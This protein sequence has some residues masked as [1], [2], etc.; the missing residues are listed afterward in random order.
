VSDYSQRPKV[1]DVVRFKGGRL[2]A[3]VG[4]VG[5][6]SNITDYSKLGMAAY[7]TSFGETMAV[8]KLDDKNGANLWTL[9]HRFATTRGK[10][11]AQFEGALQQGKSTG[12]SHKAWFSNAR[13]EFAPAKLTTLYVEGNVASGGV[14]NNE[15]HL[16]DPLYGTGHTPYGLLDVQ[17]LRNMRHLEIGVQQQISKVLTGRLSFNGYGLYDP[18]DG[19]Y[20]NGGSINRRPG[21]R[22]IDTTGTS[23]RDVGQEFNLAFAWTPNKRDTFALELGVFKPGNF[24]K[25]LVGASTAN[26]TWGLLSYQAKF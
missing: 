14:T 21:G 13:V 9:D 7:Q 23:G 12:R 18:A 22:L 8:Y 10:W 4:K 17:G 3:F 11:K 1:Y 6:T 16:F 26:Q 2:D 20:N 5:M 24:V 15:Q 19:W 25:K